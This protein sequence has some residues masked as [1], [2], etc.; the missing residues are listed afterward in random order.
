MEMNWDARGDVYDKLSLTNLPN[1]IRKE[2]QRSR[3]RRRHLD[4]RATTLEGLVLMEAISQV[5][6]L[7]G[8][9]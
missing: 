8:G 2:E 1:P 6:P 4:R 9:D 3:V 5:P 7:A